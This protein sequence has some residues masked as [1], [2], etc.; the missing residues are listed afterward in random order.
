M[1][2][3]S[4]SC[5]HVTDIHVTDIHVTDSISIKTL[6]SDGGTLPRLI[7]LQHNP[8]YGT[9]GTAMYGTEEVQLN[10]MYGTVVHF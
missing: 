3:T 7:E 2:L 1:L 9:D 5:I 4:I 6:Q 10:P 8:M